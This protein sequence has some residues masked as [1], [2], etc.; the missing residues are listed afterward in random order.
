MSAGGIHVQF[1]LTVTATSG[2]VKIIQLVVG[3]VR[4]EAVVTIA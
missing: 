3:A 2:V 4:S 1:S